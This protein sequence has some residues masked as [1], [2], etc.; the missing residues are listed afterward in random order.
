MSDPIREL[1]DAACR[2]CGVPELSGRTRLT[3]STRFTARRT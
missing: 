2:T 1:I 3:W